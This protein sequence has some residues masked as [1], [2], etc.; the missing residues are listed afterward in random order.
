MSY[1]DKIDRVL[2]PAA[3]RSPLVVDLFAGC[4]GLSLGFEAQGFETHGFEMDTDSCAT[5]RKNLKGNCTQIVLT[6]ETVLPAAPVLIGGP[7][8]QPFSVGGN[9]KGLKDSR[10]GFPIFISAV[11]K[12]RPEIWL[13]ENVRGLLYR[14]KWYL[15]EIACALQSLGY[16]VE[17]KLLNAVEF[18]VP[19]NRERVIVVGHKGNFS[20][21]K[22][23]EKK[24][25]AGEALGELAFQVP[26]TSKFLTPN[27]DAY[28]AKYEKASFCKRP[29][30]LH[31]DEPARTLTCRNLAGATGDMHRIKLPDGRRRRL[32][33]RE[34]A[35]LQSFPDWFEFVGTE[36][37]CFN[38]VGNAVSPLFA[39]HLAGMIR[40]YL[41]SEKRLSS[42][43]IVKRNIPLQ[44]SLPF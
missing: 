40:N 8:C 33:L 28:V 36:T 35:R 25:S 17:V 11:E 16:V 30:D 32:F 27:M 15:D 24:I 2:K 21:S 5:Y 41:Q 13:F 44:L 42:S 38:Q 6:P 4:G 39:F 31:L 14:N 43:E 3:S 20:F 26:A 29:R 1:L 18:G 34:A 22:V 12:L 19:Q 23:L 10:D 37:S 9:Q 7:P